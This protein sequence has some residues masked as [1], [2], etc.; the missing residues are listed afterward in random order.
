[1]PALAMLDPETMIG[2]LA[3]GS[4]QFVLSVVV[5]VE[6]WAVYKMFCL[7]RKDVDKAREE[8]KEQNDQILE[9]LQ[10]HSEAT[11]NYATSNQQLK[12]S[13]YKFADV[14]KDLK[15]D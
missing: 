11:A 2:Q 8:Q 7:W 9:V 3:V 12:E 1:M 6:S 10:T 14:V 4:A 15:S 5:V 13:I